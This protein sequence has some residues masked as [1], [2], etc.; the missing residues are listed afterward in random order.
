MRH[1]VRYNGITMI[2]SPALFFASFNSTKL[3]CFSYLLSEASIMQWSKN[4]GTC[5]HLTITV[6]VIIKK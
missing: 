4:Q 5:C 2:M 3:F 1:T 6:I